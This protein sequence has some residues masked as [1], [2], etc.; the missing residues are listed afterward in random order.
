MKIL[1]L[2]FKNINS[3]ADVHEIDF[4]GPGFTDNGIF[5][6]TGKTGA[7]K[8]SILD[9]ISL[10]LYGKTPRV[11]ITGQS[12]EVMTRGTMDCFAEVLFE[13]D[14]KQW[15]SSWKQERTR[16]GNLKPVNRQIADAAGKIYADQVR[17][18]D[19]QIVEILGLTF[20]QFTKVILLAQGSFAAFLEADK[21]EKGGLLEQ[22]T[23]TE[24]Y[25]EISKKV[26]ERNKTER[27]KLDRILLEIGAIKIL[28][29]EEIEKLNT[30]IAALEK[31][32]QQFDAELQA[33]ET[34]KKCLKD[35][36]D[37]QEQIS[38]AKTKL[39]ELE[40]NAETAKTA[41]EKAETMLKSAKTEQENIEAI[42]KKVRES[43]TKISEKE[44]QLNPVFA[45]ISALQKTKE[46]LLQRFENQKNNVEK[47][48][49][50]Q[51]DRQDWAATN[52]KYE[53]LTENYTAI[54][55]QHTQ[56][57]EL[58]KDFE[59]KKNDFVTAQRNLEDKNTNCK[60]SH[61]DFSEKES[62]LNEKT[63]ELETNKAALLLVLAGK[64]LS[65]YQSQKENITK[66]GTQIKNLIEVEKAISQNLTE[67]E[68]FIKS[69]ASA[70]KT[71]KE[72]FGK[73]TENKT[74][75]ENLGKQITL[76]DENISLAKT[77]QSLDEHRKALKDGEPCPLCGALEHPFA[78]GNKAETGEK[79]TELANVRKQY[80]E[81][82]NT[83][84]QD[85]QVRAKLISDKENWQ[86]NLQKEE[87][88]LLE[89]RNKQTAILFEINILKSDFHIADGEHKIAL[90]EEIYMQKQ[91]EYKQ[92][93][94]VISKAIEIESLVKKLQNEEIPLLQQAKQTAETAKTE[95]GTAHKLAEQEVGNKENAL[96]EAEEKY[97]KKNVELLK[98]FTEYGVEKNETL[99][100]CLTDWNT[101]KK[102]LEELKEQI[103]KME[104]ELALTDSEKTNNQNQIDAKIIEKQNIET[105]K[106][107][108]AA[109]RQNL[110]GNKQ[111]EDE[112]KRLKNLIEKAENEKAEVEKL[113]TAANTE[114]E[115][116]RAVINEKEKELTEKQAEKT[117]E[118]T[119]EELQN[120]FD[121]KK[122][123]TDEFSQKI[124]ANRQN[125]DTND[126]NLK[127]SG[128]KLKDKE[129]QQNICNKWES[130]NVLIGSQDGKKY[131]NFAQA[132][133]FEHLVGLT[134]KQLQKMSERYILKRVGDASNP[135]ELSVIDKFQNCEERSAQNLS[136]GEKFI[137]SLSLALGLANMAGKNMK[138]DTMFI[139]EGFGT[140]DTDYLDAALSALSNLQNEGKLIGVISHLA[141]LKE[142]IATHI[143]VL[144]SANGHSKTE[145]K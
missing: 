139:D 77:I 129:L 16:S 17:S 85:E 124:G 7:G 81:I 61:T 43:D 111:V 51:K 76:L 107:K 71:E 57:A 2:K 39:P 66:F 52:V 97:K 54:E 84:R 35:L 15:R 102:T 108:L 46:E 23:G 106:Q 143:E 31:Q 82:T 96:K 72:L 74:I 103:S 73:I 62:A 9:A 105:E 45:A 116:N 109:E 28:S 3:L 144:P 13:V 138:I 122:W 126:K 6:I 110:F 70:E 83:V 134:N 21:N 93:E 133:T 5:A 60:K 11:E 38:E 22:I 20:E 98:I 119:L 12:N 131:R 48:R 26:F 8:S 114:F 37:L 68:L 25:G 125:L 53:S 117:T 67:I 118:K 56:V 80:Q 145:C 88:N 14:G 59:T 30:E 29:E 78:R 86:K 112:E 58:Q 99:K 33:I 42:L 87:T 92:N 75:A 127:T 123:Q 91:Q 47:L 115:K 1:T 95:A 19:S 64:E 120:E 41:F 89:H 135:F 4:T 69:I 130:L 136:G 142:R 32:K 18:C 90:L 49:K 50:S 137:V 44:Q 34:A 132:L 141:E 128:K 65:D 113:K 94:S 140:L 100:Q 104:K 40:Q 63:Q 55:N 79:E 27:E 36:S 101:N 121:E 10:A 24:I